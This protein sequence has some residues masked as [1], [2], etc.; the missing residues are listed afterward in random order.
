[1]KKLLCIILS[2]CCLLSLISCNYVNSV[3]S[4]DDNK[5]ETIDVD[6]SGHSVFLYQDNKYYYN[7][8]FNVVNSDNCDIFELGCLSAFPFSDLYYYA[9]DETEPQYIFANNGDST[10]LF[11]LGVYF[12]E[13]FSPSEQIYTISG[14]D[15]EIEFFKSIKKCDENTVID[16][17]CKNEIY[18]S[19]KDDPRIT[20]EILSTYNSDDNWCFLKDGEYWQFDSD[21]AEMLIKNNIITF[22]S[23]N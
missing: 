15:I 14:T 11:H 21:L 16:Y 7:K 10:K 2:L 22:R 17:E 9:F 6:I 23:D 5:L 12:K 13:D 18:L 8:W 20:M 4:D 19:M 3:L 1:M